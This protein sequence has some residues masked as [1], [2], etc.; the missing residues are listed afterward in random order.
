MW[1]DVDGLASK[2]KKSDQLASK[3]AIFKGKCG[4]K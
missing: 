4:T 1:A 2:K 3:P